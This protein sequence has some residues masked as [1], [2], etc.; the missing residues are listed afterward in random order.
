[1]DNS[2]DSAMRFVQVECADAEQLGEI[3]NGPNMCYTRREA[4]PFHSQMQRASLGELFFHSNRH[5]S[6]L[7]VE[8]VN[9]SHLVAI[10]FMGPNSSP[11]QVM[12]ELFTTADVFLAGPRA[13]HVANV[14]PGQKALQIFIPAEVLAEE[15]AARLNRDPIEF[16]GHRFSLTIGERGVRELIEIVSESL[17]A[18][19]ELSATIPSATAVKQLQRTQVERVAN[20]LTA[21]DNDLFCECP[22]F[23]SRG[24]VL[25]QAKAYFE[26]NEGKPIR[27]ADACRA[28]G[29]AQRTLQAAFLEGLG[30]SP[31]RYLKLRRLRAVRKRLHETSTD[32]VTVTLAAREAGFVDLSR[33]SRDYKELFGELP[34]ETPRP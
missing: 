12:G 18:T 27:L 1:M 25:L 32:E 19:Q 20:V 16:T 34:S 31:M 30:V 2:K 26:E 22:S 29:V 21:E 14:K 11:R 23:S 33:F 6:S 24:W 7:L 8:G 17:R 13:E 28:V 15:I 3:Y 4:G 9:P 5:A 10:G